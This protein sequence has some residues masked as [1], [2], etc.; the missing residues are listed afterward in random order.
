MATRTTTVA[1][2]VIIGTLAGPVTK[3]LLKIP[4][5]TS[6]VG[7]LRSGSRDTLF[8]AEFNAAKTTREAVRKTDVVTCCYL[9]DN[10]FMIDWQKTLIDASIAEGVRRYVACNYYSMHVVSFWQRRICPSSIKSRGKIRRCS[11]RKCKN[12]QRLTS[13]SDNCPLADH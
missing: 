5:Y 12:T 7:C 1:I 8:E 13:K 2:A 3:H 10:N 6:I 4:M 11:P 9:R